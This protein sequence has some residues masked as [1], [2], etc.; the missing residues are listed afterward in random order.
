MWGNKIQ[1][2]GYDNKADLLQLFPAG[3][4]QLAMQ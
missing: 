1:N 2:F 3:L 4:Q